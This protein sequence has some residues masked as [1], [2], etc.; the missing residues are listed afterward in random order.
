MVH[1][2]STWSLAAV[3]FLIAMNA[4][5]VAGEYAVVAAK[6]QHL[7]ALRIRGWRRTGEA[8][9]GFK[10]APGSAIGTIQVCITMTNLLLGWIGEPAMSAVLAL[11]LAPLIEWHPTLFGGVSIAMSFVVVTLLTV[12]FSELLPK[13]LTLQY[14]GPAAVMTAVPIAM[15]QRAVRPLV[16]VMNSMANL[17]TRP[18]GLGK[19]DEMEEE[20]ITP[21]TLQVLTR[22][23]AERGAVSDREQSLILSSLTIGRRKARE[24][25]VPRV[26]VA[27]LD[28][29]RS[30]DAN[31]EVMNA[32]LFSRLPLCNGGMDNVIG[33]VPTKEFLSA[34]HA[35]GDSSVLSL[36]AQPPVF[37]PENVTLE[38]LLEA[39]H[40]KRTQLIF[41]V[42]EYGGVEGIVTLQDVVDELLGPLPASS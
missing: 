16:W 10:A 9:E 15:I 39:F 24:I 35:A 41:L 2:L 27:H 23:A 40:E 22:Q 11:V 36:L 18:L 33:V 13:A 12:V 37:M 19:V 38:R 29:R 32:R 34:Y 28:L 30:M 7:Q 31:R 3:P 1:M 4:F 42:D 8:I 17:V 20:Q 25:M 5:F 26:R 6:P 14:I 21:D